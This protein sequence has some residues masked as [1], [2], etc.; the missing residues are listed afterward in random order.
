MKMFSFVGKAVGCA[1]L[2]LSMSTNCMAQASAPAAGQYQM[3][4]GAYTITLELSGANLVVK[5]PAGRVSTYAPAADGSYHYRN[6]NNGVLYGI[7]SVGNGVIEAFKPEN[8]NAA[9]TRLEKV[10][11]AMLAEPDDKYAKLADQYMEKAQND[12]ANV[13]SWTACA[14]VAM[15]RS[16]S[17]KSDADKYAQEMAG[18]LK[19]MSA[20][21]SPCPEV[22]PSS[23]F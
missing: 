2:A 6:P 18:M 5:E 3:N 11:T 4:G 7:R 9:P 21:S 15:K 10:S 12:A 23:M 16:V 8:A 1:A 13:Q 20:T 19:Q 17:P 22:I 14:G